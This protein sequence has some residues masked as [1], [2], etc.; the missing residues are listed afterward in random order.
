MA[1]IV[2]T[3]LG[4]A[5]RGIIESYILNQILATA[6]PLITTDLFGT[7]NNI[8]MTVMVILGIMYFYFT[9]EFTGPAGKIIKLGRYVYLITFGATYASVVLARLGVFIPRLNF[10]IKTWLGL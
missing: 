8:L 5:T 1:I 7:F 6:M 4:I 10:L 3:G 2:G 9:K